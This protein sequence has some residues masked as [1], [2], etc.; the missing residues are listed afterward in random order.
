MLFVDY[1]SSIRDIFKQVEGVS[2]HGL[3]ELFDEDVISGNKSYADAI[4][5]AKAWHQ[6]KILLV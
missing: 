4:I 6:K 1:N 2:Q 5:S 3:D